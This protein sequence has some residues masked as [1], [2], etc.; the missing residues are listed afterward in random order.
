MVKISE[1]VTQ[2]P[3][4]RY[5][6]KFVDHDKHLIKVKNSPVFFRRKNL[7]PKKENIYVIRGYIFE[8]LESRIKV[9]S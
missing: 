4:W 7:H 8:R 6:K 2:N 9:P 5:G 1:I 3:W